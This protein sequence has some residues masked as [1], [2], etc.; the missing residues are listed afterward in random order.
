MFAVFLLCVLRARYDLLLDTERLCVHID[1]IVL[2][3]MCN[4]QVWRVDG[5]AQTLVVTRVGQMHS[6]LASLTQALNWKNSCND[7]KTKHN[8]IHRH[9][10]RSLK[11]LVHFL[12]TGLLIQIRHF[13]DATRTDKNVTVK[14]LHCTQI[15]FWEMIWTT[16]TNASTSFSC[17]GSPKL[18]IVHQAHPSLSIWFISKLVR[19][20]NHAEFGYLDPFDLTP[21]PPAF[22]VHRPNRLGSF[23][24]FLLLLQLLRLL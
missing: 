7:L 20:K 4:V 1:V 18:R 21:W 8:R 23:S 3:A 12:I 9:Q 6:S 5:Q 14:Q 11:C 24:P 17:C 16:S 15:C 22:S 13:R 19:L 10:R 2:E